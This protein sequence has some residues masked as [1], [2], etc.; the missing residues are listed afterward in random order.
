MSSI[1]CKMQS[2]K[3]IVAHLIKRYNYT[4]QLGLKIG[5]IK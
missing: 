1:L 3:L 5:F 2:L 4:Y